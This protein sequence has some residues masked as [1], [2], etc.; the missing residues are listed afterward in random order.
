[1][2]PVCLHPLMEERCKVPQRDRLQ[3]AK[4]QPRL[5]PT[6]SAIISLFE[7]CRHLE[8]MMDPAFMYQ[9]KTTMR[10]ESSHKSLNGQKN[11]S[12]L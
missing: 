12:L 11:K 10:N 5:R 4:S 6:D 1:M 3:P 9:N 8:L 7:E 2:N